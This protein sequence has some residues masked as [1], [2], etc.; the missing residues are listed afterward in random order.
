MDKGG[1]C[2]VRGL[3]RNGG[4]V[5]DERQE[6]KARRCVVGGFGSDRSSGKLFRCFSFACPARWPKICM[7]GESVENCAEFWKEISGECGY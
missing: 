4:L 5:R 2:E 7:F 1:L 6:G 3:R